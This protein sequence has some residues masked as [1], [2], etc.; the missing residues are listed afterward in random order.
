MA[1]ISIVVIIYNKKQYISACLDSIFAQSLE[2]KEVIC[3]DDGSTDGTVE[4]LKEYA[5]VHPEMKLILHEE[6]MGTCKSRYDGLSHC[7][8][9]YMTYIDAD[10]EYT[11]DRL[12][13]LYETAQ[14][15]Q[16]DILEFGSEV[17]ACGDMTR[18]RAE[19]LENYLMPKGETF[20][21][22]NLCEQC[23]MQSAISNYLFN[24][25][26]SRSVYR[27][28]LLEMRRL[29]LPNLSDVL[30]FLWHFLF[31]ARSW[32]GVPQ[33]AYRY[34]AGRG[35]T[36]HKEADLK[37]LAEYCG[38][39]K[40]LR[41]LEGLAERFHQENEYLPVLRH[42]KAY[43]RMQ[44][45]GCWV[46][47]LPADEVQSGYDILRESYG[48]NDICICLALQCWNDWEKT[49]ERLKG[50]DWRTPK[51]A[52]NKKACMVCGEMTEEE[53][54]NTWRQ[55]RADAGSDMALIADK[56]QA[57]IWQWVEKEDSLLVL[58]AGMSARNYARRNWSLRILL[59]SAGISA[60]YLPV[61]RDPLTFWDDMTALSMGIRVK[62][63]LIQ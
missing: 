16:V 25:L 61:P 22:M 17:N 5:M 24:K 30:Y 42:L 38:A 48:S 31:F 11:G 26:Y 40:T 51:P 6:N 32:K 34:Y 56:S 58:D 7:T 50:L 10:D 20:I 35:M 21:H 2:E 27:R 57:A 41:E 60:L 28:A 37:R 63:V 23:Y 53:A 43:C 33:K 4:I 55:A 46:G 49:G 44:S 8:G 15:E 3:V 12:G 14:R 1:R 39:K 13:W 52:G 18:E 36:W 19:E 45:I 9:E 62:H 59:E 29:E 47:S 54:K